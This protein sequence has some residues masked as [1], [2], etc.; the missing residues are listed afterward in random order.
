MVSPTVNAHRKI[1][2]SPATC[3]LHRAVMNGPRNQMD[4]KEAEA[5]LHAGADLDGTIPGLC[6]SPLMYA[7]AR[8]RLAAARW[9]LDRRAN[10]NTR[11]PSGRTV[12][13]AAANGHTKIVQMLLEY[14]ADPNVWNQ[15]GWTPLMSAASGHNEIARL[16]LDHG[17]DPNLRDG[18][19][20]TALMY[21]VWSECIE[22]MVLL[23]E[24]GANPLRPSDTERTLPEVLADTGRGGILEAL[25]AALAHPARAIARRRMTS[26]LTDC[27]RKAWL[28]KACAAETVLVSGKIWI[29]KP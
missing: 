14:G 11:D 28:P 18:E 7:G 17:A 22:I 26:P 13:I 29:R 27:Q 20:Q 3:R 21:A 19:D 25:D 2:I 5:A 16:L 15:S 23:L 10:P 9:L 24:R 12:L 6:E 8:G 4:T 1:A